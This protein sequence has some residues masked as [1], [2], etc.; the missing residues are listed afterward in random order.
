MIDPVWLQQAAEVFPELRL[1]VSGAHPARALR[2]EEEPTRMG[3]ALARVILAQG[4]L[5]PTTIVLEN[6]HWCDEDSM[7]VLSQ[8]GGRLERSGVLLCLTYRR[9]E[10]EQSDLVW[11][12]I[13]KLEALP[14]GSRLIVTPLRGQEVRGLISA[15]VGPA[16]LSG[17]T[18]SQLVKETNGNPLYVLEAVRNPGILDGLDDEADH[19]LGALDLPASV[20][21]PL[22]SRLAA[23]DRHPLRLLRGLAALSEPASAQALAGIVGVERRDTL[24]ELTLLVDGGFVTDDERGICRFSHEQ[25]RRVSCKRTCAGKPMS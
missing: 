6:I 16:G 4:G 11:S 7:Q 20:V 24:Q 23:L 8:L 3:E 9:F 12:G 17:A 2:P 18:V 25:T 19:L 1:L 15:Y 22:E 10:A 5:G 14:S 21:R 13:S